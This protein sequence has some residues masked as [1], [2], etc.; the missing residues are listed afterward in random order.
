MEVR[1]TQKN[2]SQAL[3]AAAKNKAHLIEPGRSQ[4]S[5]KEEFEQVLDSYNSKL[6]RNDKEGYWAT[7]IPGHKYSIRTTGL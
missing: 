6:V 2:K 1:K 3:E 4:E 5:S 7:Y